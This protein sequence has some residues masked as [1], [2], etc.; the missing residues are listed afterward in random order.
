MRETVQM[1]KDPYAWS[2]KLYDSV[3]EPFAKK[4]R[5]IGDDLFYPDPGMTV[6]D[7]GCGTGTHL[8]IY[9]KAGCRVFGI[10][11]SPS[12][13]EI[14]RKKLD[15]RGEI[16]LGD[17][18]H[19]PFADEA[20]DFVVSSITIHEMPAEVRSAVMKETKRVLK[21][22]GRYLI[23]DYHVGETLFPQIIFHR[24]V[25]LFFE[26]L[27]GREHYQNYREFMNNGGLQPY[28]DEC[29]YSIDKQKTIDAGEMVFYLLQ[30]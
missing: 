22:S 9:Q 11:L 4:L 1:P 17:A 29:G 13:V 3:V 2:A 23:I 25:T 10:D 28:I 18:S 21:M 16:Y 14:S 24:T 27:A 30:K 5:A 12:M 19:L 7:I 20:F 26:I 6:L 15:G 8:E